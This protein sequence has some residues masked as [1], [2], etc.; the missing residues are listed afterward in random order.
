MTVIK[1]AE[2]YLAIFSA[3][4]CYNMGEFVVFYCNVP[5]MSPTASKVDEMTLLKSVTTYFH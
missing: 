4:N 1:A 2:Y 5:H 3:S